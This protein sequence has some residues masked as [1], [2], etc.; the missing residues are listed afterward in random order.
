MELRT[1]GLM[2]FMIGNR[3]RFSRR[4]K[5]DESGIL[6]FPS[7]NNNIYPKHEFKGNK[8]G[9]RSCPGPVAVIQ[10]EVGFFWLLAV[11]MVEKGLRKETA[12]KLEVKE[13]SQTGFHCFRS[14]EKSSH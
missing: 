7:P 2:W 5:D 11:R 13:Q 1:W 8:S 10:G 3:C 12:Y 14:E 4:G 9:G 6:G